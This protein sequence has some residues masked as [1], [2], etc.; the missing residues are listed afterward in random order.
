MLLASEASVR[1]QAGAE[2][3]VTLSI[4]QNIN[5]TVN[6]GLFVLL[7]REWQIVAKILLFD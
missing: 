5:K 7:N 6:S 3:E 1:S 2:V 4:L